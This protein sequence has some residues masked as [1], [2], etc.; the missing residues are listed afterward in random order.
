MNKVLYDSELKKG[1]PQREVIKKSSVCPV[2][3]R[4]AGL[5]SG[6]RSCVLH[7]FPCSAATAHLS[8]DGAPCD[9]AQIFDMGDDKRSKMCNNALWLS[10]MSVSSIAVFVYFE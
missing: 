10:Q 7:V 8:R 3:G 1:K 9:D 2:L 5:F 6:N 4:S